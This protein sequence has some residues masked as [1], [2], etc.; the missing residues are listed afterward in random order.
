MADGDDE[1]LTGRGDRPGSAGATGGA[2]P[3]DC[4]LC[5][6]PFDCGVTAGRCCCFDRPAVGLVTG[7]PPGRCVCPACLAAASIPAKQ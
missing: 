4:P 3:V 7:A 1:H 5:G 2:A 6:V